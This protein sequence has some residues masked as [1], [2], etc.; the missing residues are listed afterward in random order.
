METLV[1]C[2]CPVMVKLLYAFSQVTAAGVNH[3][4]DKPGV[5]L[6]DFDKVIATAKSSKIFPVKR[7]GKIGYLSIF[8]QIFFKTIPILRILV[9]NGI[10]YRNP[11]FEFFRL[12]CSL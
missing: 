12:F 9:G 6:L 1:Q 8:V 5:G 11:L 3:Q 10:S 7:I 4:P 2:P